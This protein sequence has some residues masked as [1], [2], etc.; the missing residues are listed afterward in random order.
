VL[1]S[2]FIAT[3]ILWWRWAWT[4]ILLSLAAAWLVVSWEYHERIHNTVIGKMLRDRFRP[5]EAPLPHREADREQLQA[6]AERKDG[7][8][9]VFSGHSAFIGSGDLMYSRRILLDVSSRK[10]SGENPDKKLEPFTS[11]DIHVAIVMAFDRHHGLGK[12]L[13]N[14]RAYERLFV[15]GLH[16]QNDPQLLPDK[17]RPPP[18]SVDSALLHAAAVNPSPEARTYVCIEMPGWQG[19]LVVTLFIRA[20]Y[21]GVTR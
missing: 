16:V 5:E 18:T 13:D 21:A 4:L 3:S 15:N 9:V 2:F 8:L 11:H 1:Q 7:N 20:V 6:I 17:L 10:E 14:I 19:Q 12:S